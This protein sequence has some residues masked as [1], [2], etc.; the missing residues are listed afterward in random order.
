MHSRLTTTA[1]NV[2]Q[3]HQCKGQFLLTAPFSTTQ[4]FSCDWM[5]LFNILDIYCTNQNIT[6]YIDQNL[7]DIR[8]TVTF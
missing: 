2:H 8:C 3:V 6:V 4:K 1:E 7:Y 5:T